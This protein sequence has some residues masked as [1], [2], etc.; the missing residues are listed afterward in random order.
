MGVRVDAF[1]RV[2]FDEQQQISHVS[3]TCDNKSFRRLTEAF[4]V[5]PR[6]VATHAHVG[7]S[8]ES[9]VAHLGLFTVGFIVERLIYTVRKRSG[10]R[11]LG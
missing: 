11:R 7:Q 5:T 1:A 2:G 9:D 3:R 4:D 6:K 10:A 8:G